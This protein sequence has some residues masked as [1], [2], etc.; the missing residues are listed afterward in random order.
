MTGAA[1][2][3]VNVTISAVCG[4]PITGDII[5]GDALGADRLCECYQCRGPQ[6]APDRHGARDIS[7][8][9]V[10]RIFRAAAERLIG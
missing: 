1:E 4:V 6:G 7:L 10:A 9:R 3:P 2:F 8:G 5:A